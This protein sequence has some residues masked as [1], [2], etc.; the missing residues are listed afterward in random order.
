MGKKVISTIYLDKAVLQK[1]K[2]RGLNVSKTSENALR[3]AIRLL[4]GS[5]LNTKD[6]G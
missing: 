3:E 2:E 6:E 4:E 1:A 5:N